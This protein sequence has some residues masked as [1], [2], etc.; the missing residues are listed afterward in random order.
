MR[1]EISSRN[2]VRSV[3]CP[4]HESFTGDGFFFPLSV[5]RSSSGCMEV[6]HSIV[7]SKLNLH[8]FG[9]LPFVHFISRQSGRGSRS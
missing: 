6:L 5:R 2:P 3:K 8:N 9:V 4:V 7:C 1:T